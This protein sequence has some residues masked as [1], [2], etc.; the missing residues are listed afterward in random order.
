MLSK[1]NLFIILFVISS[2]VIAQSKKVY[3]SMKNAYQTSNYE[4]ALE[5]SDI[6]LKRI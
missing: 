6:I 4:K 1:R 5:L 3:D 2:F